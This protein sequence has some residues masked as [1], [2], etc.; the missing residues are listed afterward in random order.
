[1]LG[2]TVVELIQTGSPDIKNASIVG[3]TVIPASLP[4]QPSL[5]VIPPQFENITDNS[6][7]TLAS[8]TK[9]SV[10]VNGII[11]RGK[12]N[13]IKFVV[14]SELVVSMEPHIQV[15]SYVY[16]VA[17]FNNSTLNDYHNI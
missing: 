13:E 4:S 15:Y 9:P 8:V 1:M 14:P 2:N 10:P 7:V 6:N 16:N 12:Q 3:L 5:P 11:N 17:S